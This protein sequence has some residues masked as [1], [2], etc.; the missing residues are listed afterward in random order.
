MKKGLYE[1]YVPDTLLY[2]GEA[3]QLHR[4]HDSVLRRDILLYIFP[5]TSAHEDRIM[6]V[7][8]ALQILDRGETAEEAFVILEYVP[9][10]LL[11]AQPKAR[12]LSLKEALGMARQFVGI[13]EEANRTDGRGLL[14]TKHNLWL[15]EAGE[16]KM[17]NSWAVNPA[18]AGHEIS[19]IFRLMHH[20]MFGEVSIELPINQIIEEMALSYPGDP[21]VIRKSLRAI[22]RR[23][24][25]KGK[26]QYG[27]M[28]AQTLEDL[29]SLYHYI[30]KTQPGVRTRAVD[31]IEEEA[32]EKKTENLATGY[33]PRAQK[34]MRQAKPAKKTRIG[35]RFSTKRIAA[36]AVVV[37]ACVTIFSALQNNQP[38]SAKSVDPVS[39]AKTEPAPQE[40]KTGIEVPDVEG[41]TLAEAGQ[42]LNAAGLRYK[43]YLETSISKSGIVI[44][45]NPAA[46]EKISRID[47]VELQVSE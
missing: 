41:L 43:Y 5:R 25:K 17:V 3:G 44:K 33:R 23:E 28:I 24:E 34:N 47:V 19:D 42:K 27:H 37:I 8:S 31:T 15:T 14:F 1:R 13:L 22:W 7:S 35:R 12:K 11:D 36:I 30:K 16:V 40:K 46:G 38:G 45:Q 39:Q 20:L 32:G 26:E 4:G 6:H 21:F 10:F 29:T 18:A 2:A 9:G